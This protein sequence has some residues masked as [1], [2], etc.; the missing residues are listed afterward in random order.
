MA[1]A[2]A[3]YFA[4]RLSFF[5]SKVDG[6]GLLRQAFSAN[7]RKI[8]DGSVLVYIFIYT[9]PF[10]R[11]FVKLIKPLLRKLGCAVT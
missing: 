6:K 3:Y 11:V 1:L 5:D 2:H 8:E 10:S 4:A 9:L 7:S